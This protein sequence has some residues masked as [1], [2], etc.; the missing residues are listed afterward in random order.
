[1]PAQIIIGGLGING[2]TTFLTQFAPIFSNYLNAVLGPQ[3]NKTFV[4][5][6]LD[7]TTTY[8]AVQNNQVG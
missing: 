5:V 1:M 7:F 4:T 2:Q 8:T 6:Y 3:L